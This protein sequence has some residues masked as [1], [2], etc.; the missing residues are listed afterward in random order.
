MKSAHNFEQ[1]F[2]SVIYSH[3][4]YVDF[5]ASGVYLSTFYKFQMSVF[6]LRSVPMWQSRR[7]WK[8]RQNRRTRFSRSAA[9]TATYPSGG[10][11][12]FRNTL[13]RTTQK[14]HWSG[15]YGGCVLLNTVLQIR[16][17][18]EPNFYFPVI[19]TWNSFHRIRNF[20]MGLDPEIF[21][22]TCVR[23]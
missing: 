17:R 22:R 4:P 21:Y 9:P 5:T 3:I 13:Q 11:G 16:V 20:F 8:V 1:E 23:P 14:K 19:G 12:P 2:C 6:F 10:S 18:S 7:N 15:I